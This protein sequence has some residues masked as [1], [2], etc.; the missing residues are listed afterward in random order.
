LTLDSLPWLVRSKGLIDIV[1]VFETLDH[2][3]RPADL[4]R[5]IRDA[6]RCILIV[7]HRAE[8]ANRQ[9]GFGFTEGLLDLL[10][11]SLSPDSVIDLSKDLGGGTSFVWLLDFGTNGHPE[12]GRRE[13]S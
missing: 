2:V 3:R 5:R 1:G 12:S 6:A 10:K 11:K 7:Q 8:H 4:L 13:A 9:H